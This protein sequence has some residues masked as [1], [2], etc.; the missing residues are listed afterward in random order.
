MPN[1]NPYDDRAGLG[2]HHHK[3]V[4]TPYWDPEGGVAV[5]ATYEYG[6]PVFNDPEF[7]RVFGQVSTV[8]SFPKKLADLSDGPISSWLRETRF[9]FR[10][11]GS[12]ANRQ[13]GLFTTLGGGDHYR[14]FD[15]RERQGNATW[16]GSVEWRVPIIQNVCWDVGD[17]VAGVRNVYLAPFYDVGQAYV[18]GHG[19]GE[20]AH[21]LGVG[22][23]VDVTW[24]GLIERTM[25][26][27]DFAKTIN[28]NTP[29][30][31]WFG[32]SHPF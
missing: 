19:Q 15:L 25:L 16:F 3:N 4:L 32:I 17:H 29:W 28:T 26:R 13:E 5:D 6:V 7:H 2:I 21:A 22:F 23:R 24:L 27:F 11:G 10:F 31:F 20:I 8:K 14:G 30:Q 9:A 1:V 12:W 18:N